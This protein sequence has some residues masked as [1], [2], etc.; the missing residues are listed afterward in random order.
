MLMVP[1]YFGFSTAAACIGVGVG[2]G[3]SAGVGVGVVDVVGVGAAALGPHESNK[4][5]A[6]VKILTDSHKILFAIS[7]SFRDLP[8]FLSTSALNSLPS[9]AAN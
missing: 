2:V 7:S 3:V 8:C 9:L 5:T 4:S 6:D 1:P